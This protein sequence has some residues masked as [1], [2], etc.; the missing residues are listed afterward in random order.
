MSG[1]G[2]DNVIEEDPKL[3]ILFGQEDECRGVY[4][5]EKALKAG[6][7]YWMEVNPKET[8]AYQE[9]E[10]NY[11]AE[12]NSWD[13]AYIAPDSIPYNLAR[14]GGSVP[15]RIYWGKNL[16]G[17]IWNPIPEWEEAYQ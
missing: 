1:I 7:K 8:L 13:W 4:T 15:Q 3:W 17:V 16:I 12:P 2:N 10:A 9:W 14:G 11:P 5:S 6:V